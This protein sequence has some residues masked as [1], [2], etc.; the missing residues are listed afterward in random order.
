MSRQPSAWGTRQTDGP[1]EIRM[2]EATKA[3]ARASNQRLVRLYWATATRSSDQALCHENGG[4]GNTKPKL[5]LAGHRIDCIANR[6][7]LSPKM[8]LGLPITVANA[9]TI[10]VEKHE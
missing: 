7:H 3:P 5:S 9:P 2:D 1:E 10:E 6:N 4:C 8:P